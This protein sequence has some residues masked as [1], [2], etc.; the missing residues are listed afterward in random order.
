MSEET[1]FNTPTEPV[2]EKVD[3][4]LTKQIEELKERGVD[5]LAKKSAHADQFIEFLK[6]QNAAQK[7]ELD[8]RIDAAATLEEI[9]NKQEVVVP[10]QE[11][12]TGSRLDPEDVKNLVE[13]TIVQNA[14]KKTVET[15]QAAVDAKVKEVYGEKASE[16][17]AAKAIELGLSVT[18][19]G[20]VAARSPTAFF[21]LVGMVAQ[22]PS[23]PAGTTQG[24]NTEALEQRHT[25]NAEGTWG[26][27]ERLRKEN[28]KEYFSPRVQQRLFADRKRLEENFYK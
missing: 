17:I 6:E 11:E 14:E 13:Q 12:P 1:V 4:A 25:P 28:P 19:L 7:V 10:K 22:Q 27:Y 3:G 24:I 20:G 15:N 26:Y 8:A 18:D 21:N 9:K 2:V 23:A 16:F 5:E